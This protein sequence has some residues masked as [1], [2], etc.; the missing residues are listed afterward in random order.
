MKL[1]K[2]AQKWLRTNKACEPG[3]KWAARECANIREVL[4][5]AKSDWAIWTYLRPGILTE[6]E[7]W[8]FALDCAER[9]LP[10]FTA[11]APNDNRPAEAIR[12]KRLHLDGKATDAELDAARDAAGAAR[13]AGDAWAAARAARAAR[14]AGDAWAAARDA[15]D[16]WAARDAARAAGDAARAA[17]AAG[18]AARAA[19]AAARAAGD[20]E[21]L[22]QSQWLRE[23]TK[24]TLPDEAQ[25]LD[26]LPQGMV[27]ASESRRRGSRREKS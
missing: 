26:S 25:Q 7:Q 18:D 3:Y 21:E 24:P 16:A 17:G 6:R 13:D 9:A 15:G 10:H 20:A 11:W 5:T 14:D 8:E 23:N 12:I 1:N 27:R 2:T 22:K 4:A 19:R